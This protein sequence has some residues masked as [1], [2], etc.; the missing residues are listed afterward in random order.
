M[1][2]VPYI[3]CFATLEEKIKSFERRVAEPVDEQQRLRE[4]K[5]VKNVYTNMYPDILRDRLRNTS[6]AL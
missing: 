1:K 4:T 2:T 3:C 6:S 5:T